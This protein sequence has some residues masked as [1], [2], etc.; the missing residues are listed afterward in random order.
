V[1]VYDQSILNEVKKV[2]GLDPEDDSF[3]ADVIMH[4]NSV[5]AVLNQ[6]GVGGLNTFYIEDATA[7]WGDFLPSAPYIGMVKSYVTLKV[8]ILF[9]PPQIQS[10]LTSMQA[11]AEQY[12]W[13]L[14][15]FADVPPPVVVVPVDPED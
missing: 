2:V 6:I 1:S 10:I 4:T 11:V 13:R 9:D 15:V 14:N 12:E 5:F 7:T 8:R 3:D